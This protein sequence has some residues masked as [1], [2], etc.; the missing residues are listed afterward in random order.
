[1]L[2]KLLALAWLLSAAVMAAFW[3]WQRRAKSADTITAIWPALV[4]ALAIIYASEG[5]GAWG[6]RS[7]IAWM[8]GSW[9][10]RLAIQ[11]MYTRAAMPPG[12]AAPRAWWLYQLL[13]A[14]AVAASTPALLA[15]LN[16]AP[17]LSIVELAASAMWVVGFTGETTADRQRL[18]FYSKPEHTELPCTAGLWRYSTSVDRVFEGLMWG[19]YAA[20]GVAALGQSQMSSRLGF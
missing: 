19:A 18:R 5:D 3:A 20:F 15:S 2:L 12:E 11:G 13:A 1:M 14:A 7:A 9:G 10:A 8:M 17:E 4:G 16:R 6:R